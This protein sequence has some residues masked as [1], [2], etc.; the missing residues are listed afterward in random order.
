MDATLITAPTAGAPKRSTVA[1]LLGG[2]HEKFTAMAATFTG[3][4]AGGAA[5]TSPVMLAALAAA[6]LG[7]VYYYFKHIHKGSGRKS[8]KFRR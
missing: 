3:G 1:A 8:V 4:S 7:A 6:A 2:A 5:G